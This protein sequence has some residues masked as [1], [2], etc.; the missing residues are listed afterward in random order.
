MLDLSKITKKL[1]ILAD[2]AKYDASCAS[3]GVKRKREAGGLGNAN[4]MGICHSYTPD[5]R[6]VSLLKILLTN[7]CIYD[8]KFC[9]N[10]ASSETPRAMMTPEEVAALTIEFYRRNYIEGLFLSSGIIISVDHTMELL[11]RSAKLLRQVHKFG[12]YIHLKVVPG[13]SEELVLEAGQFADRVSANIELPEQKDLNLL[14]PAKTIVSA[15]ETMNKIKEKKLI[16]LDE[17][18]KFKSVKKFAPGGQS[19]Q[20]IVGATASTDSDILNR[21]ESLYHKFDLKRVYYSAYSPIPHADA[22]LPHQPP[23]L[24]RENRLYQA[25]WLL[26]FYGFKAEEI[27]NPQ[28]PHLALDTDP[29]TSWALRHREFFPVDI[30]KASREQ[31]LRVPGIGVRNVE[32]IL[33]ARMFKALTLEDLKRMRVVLS[34][35]KFFIEAK[36]HNSQVKLI[37]SL[38][39]PKLI[40]SENVQLSLFEDVKSQVTGEI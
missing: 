19:T 12:G 6:C 38:L 23:V 16:Y 20:M 27:V 10:R 37:D 14:A 18:K 9:V 24:Q 8:C 1:E 22:V 30:N 4:G 28:F 13:A 11:I 3:S 2:A 34:K 36:T 40:K 33:K 21:S 35:A 26:R 15:T 39:L 31:L 17:Y 7:S 25:D 32:R 5:G 29:K